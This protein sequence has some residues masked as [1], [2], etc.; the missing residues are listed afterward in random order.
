MIGLEGGRL[1]RQAPK[2][3][4]HRCSPF[5]PCNTPDCE[6][7]AFH[8]LLRNKLFGSRRS[9]ASSTKGLC[10]SVQ[11]CI[12][13]PTARGSHLDLADVILFVQAERSL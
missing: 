1:L 12:S 8:A 9:K 6:F 4:S 2:V 5:A 11:R 10:I 3:H 13:F 7:S